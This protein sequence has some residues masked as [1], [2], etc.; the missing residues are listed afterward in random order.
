MTL[1][2]FHVLAKGRG[3]SDKKIKFS[4]THTRVNLVFSRLEIFLN[5]RTE[6]ERESSTCDKKIKSDSIFQ[7]KTV[8]ADVTTKIG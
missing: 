7:H 2:A 5:S 3:S 8:T 4:Y 6:M 1:Y